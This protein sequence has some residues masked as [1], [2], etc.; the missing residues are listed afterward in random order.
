MNILLWV[1]Q[2]L[3]A[4]HTTMGAVWKFSHSEQ[5]VPSLKAIP[6][7][8][9]SWLPYARLLHT[10]GLCSSRFNRRDAEQRGRGSASGCIGAASS[11]DT[12]RKAEHASSVKVTVPSTAM[13]WIPSNSRLCSRLLYLPASSK[14]MPHSNT[15]LHRI[16]FASSE[17][18]VACPWIRRRRRL[19]RC[20]R[21]DVW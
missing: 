3:L 1:L 15:D 9:W 20:R 7:G 17:S 4:L 11:W 12:C 6:H 18:Q 13:S 14:L 10:A 16:G 2:I 21:N 5:T 19:A 8:V